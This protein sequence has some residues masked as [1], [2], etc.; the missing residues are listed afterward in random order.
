MQPM[1]HIRLSYVTIKTNDLFQDTEEGFIG[2]FDL[3]INSKPYH[4]G[5]TRSFQNAPYW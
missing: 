1:L 2:N 4:N 3:S 5:R